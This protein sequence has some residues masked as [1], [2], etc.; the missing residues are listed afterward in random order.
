MRSVT[1]QAEALADHAVQQLSRVDL[2][3]NNAGASQPTKGDL[4]DSD[5][6]VMRVRCSEALLTMPSDRGGGSYTCLL[7]VATRQV[8]GVPQ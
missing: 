4:L 7:A 2:W 1:V 5:P 6:A 8:C 3:V